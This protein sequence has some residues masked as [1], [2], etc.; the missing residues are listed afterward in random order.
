MKTA[1]VIA[2]GGLSSRMKEFKPFLPIGGLAMIEKTISNF[3][4]AGI[5]EIVVVTGYRGDEIKN[6]MAGSGVVFLENPKYHSTQM[7]DSV[8]IGLEKVKFGTDMVFVSPSDSPFVQQFTLKAMIREMEKGITDLI[9]PTFHGE[10]GHPLLL[11]QRIIDQILNHDGSQGLQGAIA[12]LQGQTVNMAFADPGILMDAD[13]PEDY[14][15]LTE[16]HRTKDC[17]SEELCREIQDYFKAADSLKAHSEKVASVAASIGQVLRE[18]GIKLDPDIIRAAGLL[19]DIAKGQ[20][21]HA[22]TAAKWL[23]DMGYLYVSEIVDEHMV[24][25]AVPRKPSEKEVVYLADKLVQD[26]RDITIEEKF[27]ARKAFFGGD[28]EAIAAVE[29][30]KEQA[31]E[32]YELIFGSL[33]DTKKGILK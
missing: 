26:D 23:K 28:E 10:K 24:L 15:K 19:H 9:Q 17:P 30:R 13:T 1:A 20:D 7:F 11:N 6:R 25:S 14:G 32:I 18:R 3:Q 5:E 4:S 33:P 29:R 27:T 16:Y 31:M 2:A 12:R 8:K 22:K 21:N